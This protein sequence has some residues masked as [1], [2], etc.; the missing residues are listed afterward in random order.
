[1]TVA[2]GIETLEQRNYLR[3]KGCDL[4]QGYLFSR[5]VAAGSVPLLAKRRF[6]HDPDP[7]QLRAQASVLPP[8]RVRLL[9]GVVWVSR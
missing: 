2:E 4:G 7:E 5:A 8:Y 9:Q 6:L 1:M 3:R